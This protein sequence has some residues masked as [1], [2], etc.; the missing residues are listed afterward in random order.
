MRVLVAGGAGY[1][2]S[3]TARLLS[4]SGW[5]VTILDSLEKGHREAMRGLPFIQADLRRP[6]TLDAAFAGGRFDAVVHFAAFIEVKESVESPL[7]YYRN[8]VAGG[9]NLLEAAIGVGVKRFVFSSTAAVYGMPREVPITEDAPVSPI[10]PYGQTK[11]DFEKA[12]EACRRSY[13]ISYTALRYFNA[14]GAHPDST[15]GEDH[16][17]ESHLIPRIISGAKAGKAVSLFG[18]DY[19]TPD[20]TC[21]RD[22]VHVMDLAQAHVLALDALGKSSAEGHVFNLG[23][24]EGFSVREV[25]EKVRKVTGLPV[26]VNESPRRA[27]DPPVLVASSQRAKAV[28]GWSPRYADMDTIIA[29]AWKWHGAHPNGYGG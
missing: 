25:I 29:T 19:P 4:E 6:E 10:N 11:A 3:H 24:G 22:Y 13:G 12:L 17:P 18:T 27:G 16:R 1:I 21:V 8:N 7:R 15:M 20:G 28:L 9:V 2:G 23:N 5:E 14:A 26:A